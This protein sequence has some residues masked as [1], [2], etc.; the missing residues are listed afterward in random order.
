[1]FCSAYPFYDSKNPPHQRSMRYSCITLKKKNSYLAAGY[2]SSSHHT[3]WGSTNCN[4]TGVVLVELLNSLNLEILNKDNDPTY[5]SAGRIE[6][7]DITLV[8]FGS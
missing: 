8:S 4:D 3:V 6:V 1:M 5:C 2:E 7:I